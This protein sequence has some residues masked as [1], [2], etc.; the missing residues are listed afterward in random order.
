ME[1]VGAGV[2][3]IV[4][5]WVVGPLPLPLRGCALGS[6]SS[7][8]AL[9]QKLFCALIFK[10]KV[11]KCPLFNTGLFVVWRTPKRKTQN[12]NRLRLWAKVDA[13]AGQMLRA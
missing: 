13:T 11:L 1:C 10:I 4:G 5:V 12:A 2:G 8:S 6:I 9:T 3:V 7:I